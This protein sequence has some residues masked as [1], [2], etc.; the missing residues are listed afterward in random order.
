[1]QFSH[2]DFFFYLRP[3]TTETVILTNEHKRI[4]NNTWSKVSFFVILLVF[5]DIFKY[6]ALT[7]KFNNL[8]IILL[9]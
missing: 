9:I 3:D 1:M 2:F 8:I 7:V 5:L 4:R 6:I